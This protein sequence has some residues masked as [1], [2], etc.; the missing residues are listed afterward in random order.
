M[1]LFQTYR[2]IVERELAED[3]VMEVLPPYAGRSRPL[4]LPYLQD[5]MC[6]RDCVRLSTS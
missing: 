3:S 1:A 6:C 5:D 4:T 2:L